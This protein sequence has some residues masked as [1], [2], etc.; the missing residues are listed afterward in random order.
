MKKYMCIHYN[1]TWQN[2]TCR[3]GVAYRDVTPDPDEREGSALRLPCIDPIAQNAEPTMIS[4]TRRPL[5]ESQLAHIA[6]RGTCE[7]L[8]LP[9]DEEIAEDKRQSDARFKEHMDNIKNDIC[10]THK[11]PIVKKQ[12]GRCVYAEPCGCRLYQGKI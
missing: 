11:I 6:R 1:G 3:A 10:P 12:V 8:R 7:K 4:G 2:L 9:T 5:S